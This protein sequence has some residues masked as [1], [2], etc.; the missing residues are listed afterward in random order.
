MVGGF[1]AG[2]PAGRCRA[3]LFFIKR[4]TIIYTR[5]REKSSFGPGNRPEKRRLRLHCGS[6]LLRNGTRVFIVL[7]S[8]PGAGGCASTAAVPCFATAQGCSLSCRLILE[9]EAAPLLRQ[10]LASQRHKVFRAPL[11]IGFRRL[12]ASGQIPI[13]KIFGGCL[14]VATLKSSCIVLFARLLKNHPIE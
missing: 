6:A 7:P 5:N 2:F 14:Q 10:C 9:R 4:N 13:G 12:F 1:L 3:V 11:F 8:D